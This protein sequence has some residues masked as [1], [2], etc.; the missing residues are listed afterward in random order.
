MQ[1]TNAMRILDKNKISYEINEYEV[2]DSIDGI[3]VSNKL[4]QN[5]DDVFKT[6]V[7][8]GNDRNNYVFVIPVNKNLDLKKCA[9]AVGVKNI[10]MLHVKDLLKTVG[11]V[12]GGCSPVGMRKQLI[13]VFDNSI[14]ERKSIFVS[15]GK[16]GVQIKININDLIKITNG[17]VADII[18]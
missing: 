18:V 6:L 17:K 7:S 10:E 2:D 12:R 15:G 4:G 14:L 13:T 1:K 9:K 3:S 8:V 11:Y 16:I 5:E